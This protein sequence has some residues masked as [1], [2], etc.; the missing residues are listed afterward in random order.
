[1]QCM[2]SFLTLHEEFVQL[3]NL[4][5]Q[6]LSSIDVK[7]AVVEIVNVVKDLVVVKIVV[8]FEVKIVVEDEV[9]SVSL[10]FDVVK[11][12]GLLEV[13]VSIFVVG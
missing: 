9:T 8:E 6:L 3:F 12:V 2:K 13:L 5:L 11:N 10:V 1:M 4:S 7:V